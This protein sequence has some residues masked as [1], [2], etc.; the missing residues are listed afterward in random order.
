MNSKELKKA[1]EKAS[2][3][4]LGE[5]NIPKDVIIL[6][7]SQGQI[8][9]YGSEFI[10]KREI[11]NIAT[12]LNSEAFM[13]F[14]HGIRSIVLR[15]DWYPRRR[16]GTPVFASS[17]SD[18][19][20]MSINLERTFA[21]AVE[22]SKEDI[23]S[24][25]VANFWL[26]MWMNILHETRHLQRHVFND[27]RLYEEKSEKIEEDA[28]K[29]AKR[30]MVEILKKYNIE[31]DHPTRSPFLAEKLMNTLSEEKNP[32]WYAAG[33]EW[34]NQQL[35][36]IEN[37]LLYYIEE[38]EKIGEQRFHEQ[39]IKTMR[40]FAKFFFS[41]ADDNWD[42]GPVDITAT[43]CENILEIN[44]IS[45]GE[46]NRAKQFSLDEEQK[47][48]EEKQ[49]KEIPTPAQET[50][51]QEIPAEQN[52]SMEETKSNEVT[53]ST[54]EVIDQE[55]LELAYMDMPYEAGDAE[56][57][58]TVTQSM[59]HPGIPQS[60]Y[61]GT[62]QK[63]EAPSKSD[64]LSQKEVERPA[65]VERGNPEDPIKVFYETGIQPAEMGAIVQGIYMK[66]SN[67]IFNNCGQ[68]LESDLGFQNPEAVTRPIPLTEREDLVI[69]KIDH[70]NE[71]GRMCQGDQTNGALTG[72]IMK[73][74]KLPAYRLHLNDNGVEKV[75]LVIPQ[76]P[77]KTN[78]DGYT[79]TALQAR[80]GNQIVYVIEGDQDITNSG[81]KKF[82][83]KIVNGKIIPC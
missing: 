46:N 21:F 20:A 12:M 26:N 31:H 28:E 53:D 61:V 55:T 10:S 50:P 13:D 24:S 1:A 9:L 66:I 65:E 6:E 51:A 8:S 77:A 40:D 62:Q 41:E 36:Y 44:P 29:W 19:G 7:T 33:F 37:D 27:A 45:E 67:H 39:K 79:K 64:V 2:E 38:G 25:I 14:D 68:L 69:E 52:N 83:L 60:G 11:I 3:Q 54:N 42:E 73:N 49:E 81:G 59:G 78:K 47:K 16:D 63:Y 56:E 48:G 32:D 80:R 18:F 76:N 43:I 82:L 71:N 22:A 34:A 35:N 72:F 57:E 23:R 17:N 58:P 4:S 15:A 70:M 74:A 5:M 30:E 75:R